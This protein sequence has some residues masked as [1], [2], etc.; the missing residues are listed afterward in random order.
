MFSQMRALASTRRGS[1]VAS[2]GRLAS[3]L[4]LLAFAAHGCGG[5][6][7]APIAG[8]D[9]V[10]PQAHVAGATYRPALGSYIAQRPVEPGPWREQDE[11]VRPAPQP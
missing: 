7:T 4:S 2:F 11:H 10:D 1:A 9:P 3:L 6:P 5:A 8:A